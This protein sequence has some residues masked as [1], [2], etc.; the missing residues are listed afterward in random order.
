MSS[1]PFSP[2]TTDCVQYLEAAYGHE[3]C[4]KHERGTTKAIALLEMLTR[5]GGMLM[6]GAVVWVL[7]CR[8]VVGMFHV[9][10]SRKC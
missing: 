3:Q 10:R 5:N 8:Y 4:L 6:V 1:S 2:L 7:L 9:A